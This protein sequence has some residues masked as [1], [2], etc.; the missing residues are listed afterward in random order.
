[1]IQMSKLFINLFVIQK[2]YLF[3]NSLAM[4]IANLLITS[5]VIKMIKGVIELSQLF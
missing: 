3:V 2:I 4:Y 5:F 1:M